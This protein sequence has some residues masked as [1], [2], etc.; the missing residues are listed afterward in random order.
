MAA[1]PALALSADLSDFQNHLT[2][3]LQAELNQSN[4]CGERISIENAKKLLAGN[5]TVQVQL[6][7]GLEEGNAVR[8]DA[9]ITDIQADGPLGDV[10]RSE[11]LGTALRDKIR[12]AMLKAIRN[13]TD[14]QAVVPA[15]A[16]PFVT[17]QS[18][19]FSGPGAGR[20]A[21]N[22]NGRLRI[23]RDQA[24]AILEQFRARTPDPR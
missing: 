24:A 2:P 10:L 12:E 9:N 5:G 21:L 15:Q 16:Q 23:P 20:V 4:R 19:A 6:T 11:P 8:L 17:L 7:P 22:L 13:S 14:L 1:L 3:L 18:V